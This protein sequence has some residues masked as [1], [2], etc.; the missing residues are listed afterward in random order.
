MNTNDSDPSPNEN[1]QAG[2]PCNVVPAPRVPLPKELSPE[3]Q[4]RLHEARHDVRLDLVVLDFA[5]AFESNAVEGVRSLTDLLRDAV[6]CEARCAAV[7]QMALSEQGRN[8]MPGGVL[9]DERN[10]LIELD[11]IAAGTLT[12]AIATGRATPSHFARLTAHPGALRLARRALLDGLVAIQSL[13]ER[14]QMET[15]H[16]LR[17]E[18]VARR[19]V[20]VCGEPVQGKH[21][22]AWRSGQPFDELIVGDSAHSTRKAAAE[23]WLISESLVAVTYVDPM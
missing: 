23:R 21:V 12:Q 20:Q 3:H 2:H 10:F 4:R 13:I 22:A 16:W 15:W 17:A 9:A 8:L 19:L 5:Q 11:W 7:E 6:T 14:Q 18:I 1:D